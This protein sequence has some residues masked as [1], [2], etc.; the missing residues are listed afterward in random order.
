MLAT[1]EEQQSIKGLESLKHRFMIKDGF[2]VVYK[3]HD[4][5]YY[6][7]KYHGYTILVNLPEMTVNLSRL[8]KS[9]I[10]TE[11]CHEKITLSEFLESDNI[12]AMMLQSKIKEIKNSSR[13]LVNGIWGPMVLMNIILYNF[14]SKHTPKV[15]KI[16]T[17]I[18]K[19]RAEMLYYEINGDNHSTSYQDASM[20]YFHEAACEE[21]CE[22]TE[23]E[24]SIEI[25]LYNDNDC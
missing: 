22:D 25:W 14:C 4:T 24:P 9:V 17:E 7:L 18:L 11:N 21:S 5:E 3:Y 19:R 6:Y 23:E 8:W 20:K 13:P 10:E 2:I 1:S 12:K 15:F 16:T